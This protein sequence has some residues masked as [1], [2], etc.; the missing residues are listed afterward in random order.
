MSPAISLET[1]CTFLFPQDIC[2]QVKQQISRLSAHMHLFWRNQICIL[3][4]EAQLV[5]HVTS[6]SHSQAGGRA[7]CVLHIHIVRRYIEWLIQSVMWFISYNSLFDW[8]RSCVRAAWD[9]LID[10]TFSV[11][12]LHWF[13]PAQFRWSL[14]SFV[15]PKKHMVISDFEMLTVNYYGFK[16][17]INVASA[18]RSAFMLLPGD[19]CLETFRFHLEHLDGNFGTKTQN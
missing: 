11:G 13:L 9:G 18:D 4:V 6:F 8:R 2:T 14:L 16:Y 7:L 3:A 10:S 15:F 5:M 17:P 12:S 1:Q 19:S